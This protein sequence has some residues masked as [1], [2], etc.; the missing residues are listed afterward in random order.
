MSEE[1]KNS[2]DII[3]K[4][5]TQINQLSR[6]I[7]VR[8]SDTKHKHQIGIHADESWHL[9]ETLNSLTYLAAM[10]RRFYFFYHNLEMEIFA[11][12]KMETL[13]WELFFQLVC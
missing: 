4:I 13:P 1:N 3:E 9:M 5:S 2:L 6:Q 10:R 7:Y 8:M 12:S 11:F